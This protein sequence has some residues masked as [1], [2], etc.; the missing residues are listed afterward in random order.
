MGPALGPGAGMMVRRGDGRGPDAVRDCWMVRVPARRRARGKSMVE[1]LRVVVG[2]LV[3][4][5]NC[6]D[7]GAWSVKV[8]PLAGGVRNS[9]QTG[10][11]SGR[12]AV[13]HMEVPDVTDA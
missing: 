3:G 12:T 1:E 9:R 8:R 6:V 11:T 2:E 10:Q 4:G 5:W 7:L 13:V